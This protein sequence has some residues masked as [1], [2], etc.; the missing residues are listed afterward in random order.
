MGATDIGVERLNPVDQSLRHKKVQSPVYRRR[1]RAAIGTVEP[2]EN[3]VGPN[4]RVAGPD[5]LQHLPPQ[6]SQ[7]G[8]M[9]AANPFGRRQRLIDA[10]LVIVTGQTTSHILEGSF[11]H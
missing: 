9:T 1:R 8:A 11:G 3:F 5:Q 7:A 10:S 2:V 6:I 4:G